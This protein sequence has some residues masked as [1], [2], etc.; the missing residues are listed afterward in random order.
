[1]NFAQF[2]CELITLYF[3]QY[4]HSTMKST[5]YRIIILWFSHILLMII[6]TK[7]I[8]S[9]LTNEINLFFSCNFYYVNFL[10]SFLF[11]FF[12]FLSQ[13]DNDFKHQYIV[14]SA[15]HEKWRS[16]NRHW[17]EK[18]RDVFNLNIE[19]YSCMNI[20]KDFD[21]VMNDCTRWSSSKDKYH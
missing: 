21:F 5:Q 16:L 19:W 14:E 15:K 17:D 12:S 4:A 3:I 10:S 9:S 1:M 13:I 11:L 20:I 8:N 18:H 6:A 7:L 2:S